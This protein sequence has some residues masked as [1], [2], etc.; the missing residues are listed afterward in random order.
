MKSFLR[1]AALGAVLV[2]ATAA[3][4]PA[5]AADPG[6]SAAAFATT[7]LDLS[8]YGE[9]RV[10]PD[11]ATIVLG[12][13]T[14]APTAVEAMRANADKAQRIVEALKRAGID[15]RDLQTSNL[16]L[17]PQYVYEQNQPPRLNGYQASNQLTVTVHDL[18]RLGAVVDAVVGAGAT[19]VGQ[20]SF[21]L[22]NPTAAENTARIAAVKA[23]QD[24]ASLYANAVGYRI[25]RLVSLGEGSAS[26]PQPRPPVPMMAMRAE[27]ATPVE[28]GELKVRVDIAGTFEL[29]H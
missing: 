16:S 22:A 15:A 23:L 8:A 4:A 3:A 14:Q 28:A 10:A 13:E 6:A 2:T 7:T 18:A 11:M 27:A 24:K 20:I 17:S 9:A 19:N 25:V 29:A 26:I 21:G 5:L 1:A 12:V